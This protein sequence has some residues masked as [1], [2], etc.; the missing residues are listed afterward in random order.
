MYKIY[1]VEYGSG[2]RAQIVRRDK[3][4]TTI[5]TPL[6][7]IDGEPDAMAKIYNF[8]CA[9]HDNQDDGCSK[10]LMLQFITASDTA[11]F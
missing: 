2:M 4:R 6:C 8:L 7:D 5:C 3:I 9:Y 1:K 10:R 11:H